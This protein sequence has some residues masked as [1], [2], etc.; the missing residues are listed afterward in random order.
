MIYTSFDN[1]GLVKVLTFLKTHNTEY[2]SG[3]DLSDVLKISRVAVWKHIKKII[4]LGYIVES[5]QKLGY[6]LTKNTELLLP[7]EITHGLKTKKIGKRVYYFDS[8]DSTQ[9]Y[10]NDIVN[11][12]KEDGALI[13][14]EKQTGGKGREGRKWASPEGGIWFSII[15][16]PKMDIGLSTLIP[17]AS[18]LALRNTISKTLKIES[19]LKWPN[20][21]TI[22]HKKVA[23]M[24][25]DIALESNKIKNLVLGI[26]INFNVNAKTIENK[27]KDT[28]NFYGVCSLADFNKTVS[29][30]EFLQKYLQELEYVFQ[31]IEKG[32]I[33]EIVNEWSK[34]SSTLGRKVVATLDDAKI[35]GIAVKIDDDGMLIIQDKDKKHR[36]VAGDVK[37]LE[38]R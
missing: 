1:P 6:R 27:F 30:V 31:S 20:D 14:A 36:I 15:M 35:V 26:G 34:Y 17:I 7:W 32:K 25:A 37:H 22:N 21:V 28:P 29:P 3:Q 9:N 18:S 19:E 11:D 12:P 24:I 38:Y 10:A 4:S 5:K 33:K 13:I 2:L 23:G 16:H 8:I